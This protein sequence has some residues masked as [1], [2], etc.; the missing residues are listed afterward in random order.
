[1]ESS[2]GVASPF[3]PTNDARQKPL[4]VL[5]GLW[6]GRS[7]RVDTTDA[8]TVSPSFAS[9]SLCSNHLSILD[10]LSPAAHLY[11]INVN[12]GPVFPLKRYIYATCTGFLVLPRAT[13][14]GYF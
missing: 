5:A 14:D 6:G 11:P 3:P 13:S 12:H 2:D 8:S 1:M 9:A 10:V 4:F 7:F